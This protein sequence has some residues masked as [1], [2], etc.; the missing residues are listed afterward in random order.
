MREILFKAKAI[1]RKDYYRSN[2]KNGD[3]VYGLITK[4]YNARYDFPATMTNENGISGIEVDYK[5]LSQYTGLKDKNGKMI[6][7]NDI[8]EFEF[9]EIG[10]QKAVVY[11][12]L[13]YGSFL[14]NVITDNFQ[15]AKIKDGIVIGNRF[16]NPEL[17]GDKI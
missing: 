3:W 12:N 8:L 1:N 10:K 6:F 4:Q 13:E 17:L 9:E 14:L 11:Y 15:F 16:D 7:E 2:Y 5:T